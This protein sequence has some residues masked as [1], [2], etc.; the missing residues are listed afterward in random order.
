[1]AVGIFDRDT[2]II[3]SG[4]FRQLG[5][6]CLGIFSL[7]LYDGLISLVYFK[8]MKSFNKFRVGQAY[9]LFGMDILDQPKMHTKPQD[10]LLDLSSNQE[11]I[12]KLEM[13]QRKQ[14]HLLEDKK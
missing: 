7:T 2:G 9:E 12:T 13:R 6:Q 5:V 3:Y 4:Q 14:A 11:K 8:L 1:M 10:K